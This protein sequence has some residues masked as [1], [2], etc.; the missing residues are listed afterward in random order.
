MKHILTLL[1]ALLLAPLAEAELDATRKRLERAG[2]KHAP[3]YI[4]KFNTETN[5]C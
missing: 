5:L 2:R 4:Q 3:F 1:T